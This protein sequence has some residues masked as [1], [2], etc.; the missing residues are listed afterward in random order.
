MRYQFPERL[1]KL[2]NGELGHKER[3]C[4]AV[5]RIKVIRIGGFL[6]GGTLVWMLKRMGEP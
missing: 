1:L 5:I 2:Q 4:G 3:L 6:L